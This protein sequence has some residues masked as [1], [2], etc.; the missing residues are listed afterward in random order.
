M[1]LALEHRPSTLNELAGNKDIKD[2]LESIFLRKADFPHAYLFHG[3]TGCGKTT[4]ARIVAKMLKCDA[5]EEYNMSNLRGIDAI[6]TITENSVY[7]PM[8]G[9]TRVYIMDEV[10][11]QTKDAQNALLKPLEDAPAH[12]FYILCTTDPQQLIE[13]IR[14]RCHTYQVKPLKSSEMM[15]L[16]KRILK[17]EKIEDY[18]ET[19][20]REICRLSEG[21]PRNA[22]VLLDSIIDIEDETAAV[23]ALSAVSL[24]DADTKELCQA[25]LKGESW[26]SVRKN[27]QAILAEGDAERTR[28]AILGY[29]SA[30]LYGSKKNDRCCRIMDIFSENTYSTG[31]P[32][33]QKM[34]YAALEFK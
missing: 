7:M 4:L 30:V 20:L 26:D 5:P 6:R 24:S 15:E 8:T 32:G 23:E 10:H 19:I 18:P 17:K 11:R 33:L 27:V 14:G 25:I 16:L 13:A 12:V 34:I 21:L 9:N 1:T 2:S 28:Y 22:L 31:K 3:P 29:L